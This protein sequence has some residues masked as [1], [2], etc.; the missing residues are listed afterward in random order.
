MAGKVKLSEA[1]IKRRIRWLVANEVRARIAQDSAV[2]LEGE[3]PEIFEL[4]MPTVWDIA[5]RIFAEDRE[6][7]IG[8][9][10]LAE[11]SHD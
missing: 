9:A 7:P 10:A 6:E 2:Y 3:A 8:R 11:S 4:W 1:Q 5:E